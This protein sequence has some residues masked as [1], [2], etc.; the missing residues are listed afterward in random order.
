MGGAGVIDWAGEALEAIERRG[1]RRSLLAVVPVSATEVEVGGR[2]VRL[3]SSNDYLGLSSHPDV[4]IAAALAAEEYGMGPRG[5]SLVCG[6][7]E[8]HE[9]L[10][11]E[12]ASLKGAEAALLF[13]TGYAA[14]LGALGALGSPDT[15]IF[16][17]ELNHASI[18]DGC[19]L[20]R[21]KV[22]VYRHRDVGHLE[23]LVAA[24]TARRRVIVTDS[25]FSMEGDTAPLADIVEVRRRHAC[26]L[27]VD[28]AHA[29]LVYG[30]R[31]GGLAEA[32]GVEAEVDLQVGTLSK[33]AGALGGF[34]ACNRSTRDWLLN[35]AR[36][37]IFT[38]ALPAPVVA[39]ALA[40]V[41]VAA[42][43]PSLRQR[44]WWRVSEFSEAM[45][46]PLAS[47]IAPILVGDEWRAVEASRSLLKRGFHVTAI[48]PPTVPAG[49]SRL[50]V[51]LSAA[52]SSTD[53]T[54]L[55]L[56][57]AGLGHFALGSH[58]S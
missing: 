1:R 33:A 51:A 35:V 48:R 46:R 12:L 22:E 52:H 16:S 41:R 17:D 40:A 49:G 24:S 14:N 50:R 25:V 9:E 4:R 43:E 15:V 44:L 8:L 57:I 55:T 7:T 45:M 37:Y 56:A 34:V 36:S 54:D 26:L 11:G 27:V 58:A 32:L 30:R 38:T 29:T 28:E 53:L 10:E 47:P 18:I 2:R 6:Y 19:R 23:S 39:A 21:S 31:G 20:A 5:A 13:P 42:R 3:F